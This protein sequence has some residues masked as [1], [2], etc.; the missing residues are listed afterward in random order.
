MRNLR[1]LLLIVAAL[2]SGCMSKFFPGPVAGSPPKEI[3]VEVA[4]CE[5]PAALFDCAT[6]PA[7]ALFLKDYFDLNGI[8]PAAKPDGSAKL[9]VDVRE[10]TNVVAI[11]ATLTTAQGVVWE[12]EAQGDTMLRALVRLELVL[13]EQAAFRQR[14]LTHDDL[15]GRIQKVGRKHL[16]AAKN[17]FEYR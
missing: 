11:R 1:A 3:T 16:S 7:V 12:T 8:K 14:Y 5:T 9:R 4:R 10:D 13:E 2:S 17:R 6:M 15:R